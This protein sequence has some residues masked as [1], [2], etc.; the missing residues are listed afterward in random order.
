MAGRKI[1]YHKKGIEIWPRVESRNGCRRVPSVLSF[2]LAHQ[3]FI[4]LFGIISIII[5]GPG[6]QN[7]AQTRLQ[8]HQFKNATVKELN[9]PPLV[10][11]SGLYAVDSGLQNF[12]QWKFDSGLP[13][14]NSGFQIQGFEFPRLWN[15]DYLT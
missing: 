4:Y 8:E 15:M 9:T 3:I 5:N 7:S 1:S 14:L 2:F 11:D 10:L 13:E 6:D 12:Y